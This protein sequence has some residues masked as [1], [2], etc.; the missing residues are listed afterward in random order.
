MGGGRG[1]GGREGGM[2]VGGGGGRGEGEGSLFNSHQIVFMV[3]QSSTVIR[4]SWLFQT[5]NLVWFGS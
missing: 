3:G 2:G 1:G 5:Q 4:S